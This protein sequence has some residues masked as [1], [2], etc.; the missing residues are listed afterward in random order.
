MATMTGR[1]AVPHAPTGRM[2]ARRRETGAS[3][4]V[5]AA[6]VGLLA[7]LIGSLPPII[8][9]DVDP[10]QVF[11][12]T[13]AERATPAPSPQCSGSINA[14]VHAASPGAVVTVPACLARETV[15]I[16]K[17]LTLRGLPGAQIR[18]TD[19]WAAWTAKGTT[20]TS[21]LTVPS[22]ESRG[23]CMVG[24]SCR[25]PEQVFR[26]GEPLQH[27]SGAPASGEF[28]LDSSRHVI[29]GDSPSGHLIEVT[30]RDAWVIIEAEG[31][32]VSGFA[33]AGAANDA[34]TG[35]ILNVAGAGRDTVRDNVLEYAHGADVALDHGNQNVI[36]D[37]DI[38]YGG[39]LGVHLGGSG[40]PADGQGNVV[41][42]NRIH[43]NNLARFDPEWEAGGLKATVQRDLVVSGNE[44]NNNIGPGLWCDIYCAR[45][46]IADNHVHD[47][48][49][50]GISYEVSSSGTI[51]GNSVWRNGFGKRRWGW[52]AGILLSSSGQTTVTDN[53]VAWNAT[54]GISV[55]SQHRTDWPDVE[56]THIS[57]VGNT[58]VAPTGAWLAFWAQDWNGPL[59]DPASGNSGAD[60]RYSVGDSGDGPPRFNWREEIDSLSAFNATPA[61]EN[62]SLMTESD[63]MAALEAARIP[64]EP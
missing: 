6:W 44:V 54:S 31:V 24:D 16:D 39:Q 12:V 52:G 61:E 13:A 49:Y 27:V 40:T 46:R 26:D 38:G 45:V 25:T 11:D 51:V 57:V 55:I 4:F 10:A 23:A 18:G 15:T 3:R 53:V 62:G 19:V 60:N 2:R 41:S 42:G 1:P 33:M 8:A 34:Q 36:A 58:I 7:A 14:L 17:P 48:T 28:T 37:N 35:A 9:S 64:L 30:V 56:A 43:D 32:T 50:A 59:F 47:N 20:W 22:F 5:R 63:R 21:A 29:L